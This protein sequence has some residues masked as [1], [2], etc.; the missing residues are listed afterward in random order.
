[1]SF[2]L[3]SWWIG[4]NVNDPAVILEAEV[5]DTPIDSRTQMSFLI[6]AQFRPCHEMNNFFEGP[7]N[8]KIF[9]EGCIYL[10][11]P[12]LFSVVLLASNSATWI[13]II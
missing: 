3:C 1:M 10:K 11:M 7:K 2:I 13:Y 4:S 8:T 5:K 12:A 6:K 9:L